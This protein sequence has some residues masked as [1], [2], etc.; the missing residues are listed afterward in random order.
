MVGGPKTFW[1]DQRAWM[2]KNWLN[3]FNLSKF[4]HFLGGPNIPKICGGRTKTDFE[5]WEVSHPLGSCIDNS[6]RVN[7]SFTH[8]DLLY[9]QQYG[10]E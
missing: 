10:S 5:D 2:T 3:W 1:E 4:T 8:L 9:R 7:K 6:V